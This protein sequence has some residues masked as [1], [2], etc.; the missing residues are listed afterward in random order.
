MLE[1]LEFIER[2]KVLSKASEVQLLGD[3]NVNLLNHGT[4]SGTSIFLDT[5]LS[6]GLLPLITL[7]TRITQ[8]SSTLIDN[9]F[10]NKKDNFLDS[11]LIYSCISDHLPIF[12]ISEEIKQT[13]DIKFKNV[14]KFNK[15]NMENF[16]QKLLTSEWNEILSDNNP[17]TA[18]DMF[19]SKL[20]DCFNFAFPLKRVKLSKTNSPVEPWMSD[21]L[22]LSRKYKN[23]LESKK[24]KSPTPENLAKFKEY[25]RHYRSVIRRA[26]LVYFE[27][28]FDEYSNNM[29]QTWN[30]IKEVINSKK[31]K[32]S[33]PSLFLHDGKVFNGLDEITEG[34]NTYFVNIG[35]ELASAIPNSDTSFSSFLGDP[36]NVNFIFANITYQK[37]Y[38]ILNQLKSKNSS[39]IDNIST[40][41]LKEIMPFI[42]DPVVHVFNLSLRSGYIPDSYKCA[43]VIPIFKSG[44]KSEFTNYRPISLLSS[45]S[46]LL[47]KIIAQQ[48]FRYLNKYKLLYDH[49]Y[50]F[51]PGHDTEQPILQILDKIYSCLNKTDNPEYF[52]G[53]FLDLKKAFDT[54]DHDILL[55]KLEHYGFRG[56]TNTWFRN[57]L[58]NRKQFISIEGT[59]STQKYIK[60]GV[61]QGS[62]LGPLLFLLFINDSPNATDFFTSLFADDTGL[63][64]S[65]IS[66]FDL[67]DR[68]NIELSKAALWFKSNKL[69][70][71]IKKTK[72]IMFRKKSMSISATLPDVRIGGVG[73]NRI[74]EDCEEKFFKF[75]GLHLDEYLSWD[76]HLSKLN[77]K[78][79]TSYFALNS[80]KNILPLKIRKTIY[81]TLFKSHM[82]F[83]ITCWGASKN[84]KIKN[85]ENIQKKAIRA[86]SNSSFNAHTIPLFGKLNILKLHDILQLKGSIFM[87]KYF[88]ER[89]PESFN[90]MFCALSHQNRT[91]CLRLERPIG[92]VLEQFPK[93]FLPQI[94]NSLSLEIK[95]SCSLNSLKNKLHVDKTNMYLQFECSK[96][97]C[98]SCIS[99]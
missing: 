31:P 50:G 11:G 25:K 58:T 41:L 75:V 39:G 37:V 43:K 99:E 30:T 96:S 10:S 18:F 19:D 23:K 49:Q 28:K 8:N 63:F 52:I 7:P 16:K 98:Y 79:S 6:K 9:I 77:K 44:S 48:I 20:N 88:N 21:A 74:G 93:V 62:V 85:I 90:N 92:K 84:K 69:T 24:I 97:N 66:Q 70:L 3:F 78:L 34:F 2:D 65:D 95:N 14:R 89:L 46:K 36:F 1:I 27:N 40:K 22:L 42:I 73:I 26:R 57:Y 32:E 72:Y 47:E 82:E 17:K 59:Q 91:K 45:F 55:N 38:E 68:S 87:Y 60:V 4:H 33:I 80:V 64:M 13:K 53:I 86:V 71:N 67:I 94:W 76:Y 5:L 51:R 56:T 54:V 81:N 15:A 61:P 35:S 29:K 12:N 83:G